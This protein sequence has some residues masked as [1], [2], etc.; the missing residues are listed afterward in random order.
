M[1]FL[2]YP[3]FGK[4]NGNLVFSTILGWSEMSVPA[5]KNLFRDHFIIETLAIL[6]LRTCLQMAQSLT[7]TDIYSFLSLLKSLLHT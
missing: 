2:A 4:M 5:T 7:E 6:P 1:P 3:K